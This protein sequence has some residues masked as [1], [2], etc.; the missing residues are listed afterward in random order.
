MAEMAYIAWE[1]IA[2]GVSID[3]SATPYPL[4]DI[5]RKHRKYAKVPLEKLKKKITEIA[6]QYQDEAPWIIDKEK[7]LLKADYQQYLQGYNHNPLPAPPLTIAEY[8]ALRKR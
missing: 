8:A 4:D 6:S 3:I 2:Q 1:G 7:M 5:S